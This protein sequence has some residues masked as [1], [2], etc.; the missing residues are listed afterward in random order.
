M[1]TILLLLIGYGVSAINPYLAF[2]TLDDLI[3]DGL[4]ENV[5]TEKAFKNYIKAG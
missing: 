1:F 5:W 3:R 4:L 2:D